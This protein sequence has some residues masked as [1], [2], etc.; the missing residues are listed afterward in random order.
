MSTPCGARLDTASAA[1]QQV[2]GLFRKTGGAFLLSLV[3]EALDEDPGTREEFVHGD[4]RSPSCGTSAP[5]G[6]P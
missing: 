5:A 6:V 4:D 3:G 1:N 2:R